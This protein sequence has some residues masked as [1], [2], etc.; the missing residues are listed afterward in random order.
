MRSRFLAPS[1]QNLV[2]LGLAF[3]LLALGSRCGGN[4]GG[5]SKTDAA[6]AVDSGADGTGDLG[7]DSAADAPAGPAA[8][9]DCV[10]SADC[11]AN[12][13]CARACDPLTHRC[14]DVPVPDGTACGDGFV[15][16]TGKCTSMSSNLNCGGCGSACGVDNMGFRE[17][18]VRIGSSSRSVCVC[19]ST[20]YCPQGQVCSVLSGPDLCKC[21]SAT[22][23]DGATCAAGQA[24]GVLTAADSVPSCYYP[25]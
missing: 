10:T 2:G 1:T 6:P 23:A 20:H 24:C 13:A 8:G 15:C 7:G 14:G 17:S 11:D 5:G 25:N 22:D 19:D 4:T 16:C 9:T 21:R 12:D 18:C 3:A